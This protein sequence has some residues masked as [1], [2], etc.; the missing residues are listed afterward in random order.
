M[1]ISDLSKAIVTG[2]TS[3]IGAATVKALAGD[4]FDVLALGRRED[5]LSALSAEVGCKTLSGDV[6]N[7]EALS[8]ELDAFEADV[9]VNNAGVGHGIDGIAGINPD[10]IQDAFDINVVA[11]IQLTAHLLVGMK[12]RSRG[13]IVNIGSIAG[14]HTLFSAVYGGTKSALHRFSQNLRTELRGTGIRVT[15]I[16]PGR[17]TTEFYQ[18]AKGDTETL[19]KMGATEIREMQP[20]DVADAIMFALKA[21][22]HVNIA[23]IEMLPTEQAVGGVNLVPTR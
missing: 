23:T 10:A 14:L 15:E 17:V 22:A 4:G 9:L 6:R 11:P 12:R 2:A 18:V 5:R 20:A 3:G 21:P 13:H 7:I 16:C 19:Q 1:A 8:D